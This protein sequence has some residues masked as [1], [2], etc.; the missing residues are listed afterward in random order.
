[1]G[2]NLAKAIQSYYEFTPDKALTYL[3]RLEHNIHI[4][5]SA[6]KM[7][8]EL[9]QAAG[10]EYLVMLYRAIYDQLDYQVNGALRQARQ[11]DNKVAK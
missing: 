7:L 8:A 6:Q 9:R 10:G 2:A 11:Q 4:G 3:R 5:Y 1:M